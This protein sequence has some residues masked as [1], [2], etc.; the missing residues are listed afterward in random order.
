LF[1]SPLGD[2]RRKQM[3]S[4]GAFILSALILIRALSNVARD[5][6]HTLWIKYIYHSTR[7]LF[8]EI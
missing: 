8:L 2:R 1:E 7:H 4:H 3:L 5:I 6:F